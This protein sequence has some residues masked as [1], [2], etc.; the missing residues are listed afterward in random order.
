MEGFEWTQQGRLNR[1]PAFNATTLPSNSRL[2]EPMQGAKFPGET[3][4]PATKTTAV[5]PFAMKTAKGMQQ[6]DPL[7]NRQWTKKEEE[8]SFRGN[9]MRTNNKTDPAAS[10][11]G[12][13]RRVAAGFT[14]ETP[15]YPPTQERKTPWHESTTTTTTS[16]SS[17]YGELPVR[18]LNQ[19]PNYT[20]PP[21]P[22][23]Y[24][25]EFSHPN[26]TW[27][28]KPAPA[29]LTTTAA[30]FAGTAQA[31][32]MNS[33]PSNQ[34]SPSPPIGPTCASSSTIMPPGS[35]PNQYPMTGL[36]P[37]AGMTGA[38]S[39]QQ[40]GIAPTSFSSYR[41]T[42]ARYVPPQPFDEPFHA[43]KERRVETKN[44]FEWNGTVPPVPSTQSNQRGTGAGYGRT[45][46]EQQPSRWTSESP[47]SNSPTSVTSLPQYYAQQLQQ[48]QQ[49]QPTAAVMYEDFYFTNE[50]MMTICH[51]LALTKQCY[52]L[53]NQ[54]MA[55]Y[56]RQH[57]PMR[58]SQD[59]YMSLGITAVFI[60]AKMEE[61]HPPAI[62]D[63]LQVFRIKKSVKEIV[64]LE[65][66]LLKI[67]K[68][69]LYP[70]TPND[71]LMM[72]LCPASENGGLDT[73]GSELNASF[74]GFEPVY[75]KAM[76][77]IDLCSFHFGT[78]DF[79]PNLIAGAGLV[80]ASPYY[81]I[82]SVAQLLQVHPD[83]LWSATC[84]M[85][86]CNEQI[87]YN[88]TPL[89]SDK[90]ES[91]WSKVPKNELYTIQP[92]F[93]FPVTISIPIHLKV[94]P[95]FYDVPSKEKMD[96]LKSPEYYDSWST[97]PSLCSSPASS[98]MGGTQV[99]NNNNNNDNNN[100]QN[101]PTTGN[102]N[103]EIGCADTPFVYHY[104]RGWQ[105]M[106]M[107]FQKFEKSYL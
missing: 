61:T 90:N 73:C 96:P 79:S 72:I 80:C 57:Y 13:A 92:A 44:P 66:S 48:Q 85:K 107:G 100:N 55:T 22:S 58:H 31:Y 83:S 86:Y 3:M 4:T 56:F 45:P 70:K 15:L 59:Q 51:A 84:W 78:W 42:D 32:A 102:I 99:N 94:D 93:P 17:R 20:G 74:Q 41:E 68:W 35:T 75:L 14:Q 81:N 64:E 1:T 43:L 23:N 28:V 103:S 101:N 40:P 25:M 19:T 24:N 34:F 105:R 89:P 12:P 71:W 30:P 36:A 87:Y 77:Y 98:E 67:L 16:T 50:I 69:N 65:N 52:A 54:Y 53:A 5:F 27:P 33:Y 88:K 60:A 8:P 95:A 104:K 6:L 2:N 9:R 63:L 10:W 11:G 18:N 29:D 62:K 106:D 49:Q 38:S 26:N 21:A 82:A 39:W 37:V 47:L 76:R 91:R 7:Q 46:T 97:T